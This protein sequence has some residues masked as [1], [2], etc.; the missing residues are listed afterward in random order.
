MEF[1]EKALSIEKDVIVQEY[2][3]G[4]DAEIYY[5]LTY[6]DKNSRC[7]GSFTGKKIRQWP[8]D[9]GSTASTTVAGEEF[10]KSE[11]IRIFNI[12][13]FRGF[14]SI[15]YKRNPLNNKFYI[16]EPTVGR[17]NQQEFVATLHGVNLPLIAYKSQTHLDLSIPEIKNKVIIYIDEW[18][19]LKS[20]ISHLIFKKMK[21]KEWY[22]S[23]KGVKAYRYWNKK[24]PKVFFYSIFWFIGSLLNNKNGIIDYVK[25]ILKRKKL[26]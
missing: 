12:L 15:E 9:T 13:N 20:T 25:T 18:A 10:I 2:I 3:P 4:G 6:Y 16:M 17:L 22:K 21:P 24:D 23:L 19:E 8:V 5:C 11:T 14:G 7:L 26:N 1:A